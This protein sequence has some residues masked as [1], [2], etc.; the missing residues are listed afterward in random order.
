MA[1]SQSIV[2]LTPPTYLLTD[3]RTQSRVINSQTRQCRQKPSQTCTAAIE[4]ARGLGAMQ[5]GWLRLPELLNYLTSQLR[6][7]TGHKRNIARAGGSFARLTSNNNLYFASP[8]RPRYRGCFS[9]RPLAHLTRRPFRLNI[10]VLGKTTLPGS[11]KF[12]YESGPSAF[13]PYA[14]LAE[15]SSR[16]A[17]SSVFTVVIFGSRRMTMR[18]AKWPVRLGRHWVYDTHWVGSRRSHGRASRRNASALE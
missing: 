4:P 7:P 9:R 5:N 13:R 15:W 2:P 10:N 14:V 18:P 17:E 8:R 12:A 6:T 1:P 11:D 16:T 3:S